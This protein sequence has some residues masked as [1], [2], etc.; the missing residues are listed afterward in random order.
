LLVAS[1]EEPNEKM[2]T[3]RYAVALDA[4]RKEA[5]VG[6]FKVVLEGNISRSFECESEDL[7]TVEALAGL[8]TSGA[9]QWLATPD[10]IISDF[11]LERI[12]APKKT[13][14]IKQAKRPQS[15]EVA[16]VGWNKL[17]AGET[18]S[19]ERLEAN[20]MRRSDAEIFSK[21]SL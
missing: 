9:A 15:A 3:F 1:G 17:R 19:P 18:V 7:L 16:A 5:F 11:L 4:G 8:V 14:I 2:S 21:P 6:Q 13:A 10:A 20:Y 12:G